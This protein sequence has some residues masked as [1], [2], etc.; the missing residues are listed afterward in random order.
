MK[1]SEGFWSRTKEETLHSL[2]TNPSLG[3]SRDEAQERLKQFGPN[4]LA[5][6]RQ[7]T[8]WGV[9][10]EEIT[11]PM[12]LLLLVVGVVYSVWGE[13]RDAITIFIIIVLLVFTEIFTEYR[14][15]KAVAALR[16]LSP[17]TAPVIRDGFYQEVPTAGIVKGDV[18][19]LE[20]GVE[21]PADAR[22]IESFGLEADESALTG[23]STPVIK[24]DV[25][26]PTDTPLAERS[27]TVFAGTTITRG[28]GTAAVTATGMETELGKITGLVLEAKEPKT[29]LQLAMKQ[30][31]GLLV[32]VAIFFSLIIPLVG[33]IQGKSLRD[34]VQTGLSLSFATIPEELPIVITMVLGVG[35]YALSRRHV[36][37]RRLRAAETL[38][39]VTVIVTDKTGTLT[40][41]KMTL[42]RVVTDS[43]KP[44]A[45]ETVSPADMFLLKIGVL[46]SNIKKGEEGGYVGDPMEIAL[47][48][49]A[50]QA[51]I[52]RQQVQE[53]FRLQ[54]EFSFDN[55]RKLVSA[56]YQTNS[57]GFIFVKGAPEAV[58]DRSSKISYDAQEKA[59][60]RADEETIKAQTESMAAEAMRVIGF[61]YKRVA[62]ASRLS[63]EEAESDLVF[64]GLAGF[65]DPP[66]TGVSQ[67]VKAITDAGIRTV[68]VSGDH[69]LTVEKIAGEVGIASQQTPITG[70]QL[71]LMKEDDLKNTVS[72]ASLF[73]RTTA[74]QK[75]KIV[76]LL[77]EQGEVVAVT[78]DGI[79]DAPALKSADIGI[80]MGETGTEVA[81]EAADMVLT[82]DSF[83]S[84]AAGVRE[85]R[86][87]F[88]N[89]KKGITYYLCVKVALVLSFLVAL[90]LGIPF[91]FAPIQII[92]LEL[93]MDLAASATF[94]AEPIEEDVMKR[95]PRNPKERFVN[96]SMLQRITAGSASLAA[97][98]TFNYLLAW[99]SNW[100]VVQAQTI[101][102]TTWLIGHTFLAFNMRSE[103]Q[104]LSKI[105]L[106][107]N[108]VMLVWAGAVLAFLI[109]ATGL[110]Q[111]QAS[112]K[113]T[114]L[115]LKGWLLALGI[116]FVTIFWMELMK[117]VQHHHSGS[118]WAI[119]N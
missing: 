56:A 6:E 84:I 29:P 58:L 96:R 50:E 26:L 40:E 17:Q 93:F 20:S 59:K 94:V 44:F 48:E 51:G 102:F 5:K 18:L 54:T 79:N 65:V 87:M 35:A 46:T 39:S 104:P 47:V 71:D 74:E 86:K 64:A 41:N 108:R 27:N 37:I 68:V 21:V 70:A 103:R 97:A 101:A 99:Y 53:E 82:D 1:Q 57:S 89:L 61:G 13:L 118:A 30:L 28:R 12:I 34:M 55:Q 81:R 14:A 112:L 15:K 60:T 75:L 52:S 24:E 83:T 25:V 33:L 49:A 91:P 95:P 8:F 76:S 98:V 7:T 73:A 19:V 85:G 45:K 16:R 113:L 23:E 42:T 109:L 2:T 4:K 32:W 77:R 22:L 90:V 9:F 78:G 92:L 107:S 117:V 88:D 36:L 105:G 38:G 43:A 69:P 66:R 111:V 72:H 116:P 100:G 62:D 80:A 31:A 67:A 110:P 119:S 115:D 3:L 10:R 63:Q 106:F 114:S 11:E